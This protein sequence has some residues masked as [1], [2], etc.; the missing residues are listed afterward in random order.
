MRFSVD[1]LS[2]RRELESAQSSERRAES[3]NLRGIG[4][5]RQTDVALV[6]VRNVIAGGM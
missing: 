2:I 1:K 6:R 4:A 3:G 5:R